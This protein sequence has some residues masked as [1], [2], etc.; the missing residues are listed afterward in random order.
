M[1][2]RNTTDQHG[3]QR[4][5]PEKHVSESGS[6]GLGG[7][8][9]GGSGGG[10]ISSSGGGGIDCGGGQDCGVLHPSNTREDMTSAEA[11]VLD[12]LARHGYDHASRFAVRLALEEGL[13]NAFLHGHR[14]L[15]ANTSLTVRF[16]VD[17]SKVVISIADQGAGFN[18]TSIPDPTLDENLE[19]PS[20]R[21]LMLIR[22]Y[23][24]GGVHHENG[25]ST[26]VMK[27]LK[28]AGE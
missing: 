23:M 11:A 12:A 15:P 24:N 14:G 19:L 3:D 18:P 2:S 28:N 20:G 26:M 5:Q 21:G 10:E 6:G 4:A 9:V 17:P 13:V 25:G 7:V 1:N 22:A 16:M 8:P 27:F